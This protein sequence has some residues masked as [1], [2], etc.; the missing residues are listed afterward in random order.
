MTARRG[1]T[2]TANLAAAA[3]SAVLATLEINQ[4][5]SRGFTWFCRG[6][7]SGTVRVYFVDHDDVQD[8]DPLQE[9]ALA[10]NTRAVLDFDYRA[11]KTVITFEPDAAA[12]MTVKVEG[13]GYG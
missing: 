5:D 4:K 9:L 8:S 7:A 1:T 3:E 11:P 2:A 6:D 10:A 12:A 13:I